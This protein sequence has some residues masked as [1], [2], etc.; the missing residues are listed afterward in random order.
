[1]KTVLQ[2]YDVDMSHVKGIFSDKIS[3]IRDFIL[4]SVPKNTVKKI[5]LFGS[6]AYGEPDEDSDIDFCII[7]D[8]SADEHDSYM[9]IAKEFLHKDILPSDVLVYTEKKFYGTD[10]P[11]DVFHTIVKKGKLLYG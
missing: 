7:I 3:F 11:I 2:K 5:Y 8:N 10:N 9:R 4:D 6:Y 1:M